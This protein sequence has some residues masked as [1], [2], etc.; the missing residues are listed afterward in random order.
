M[1]KK[2]YRIY[3]IYEKSTKSID[4]DTVVKIYRF[5]NCVAY[6]YTHFL[7]S[8][9]QAKKIGVFGCKMVPY[10]HILDFFGVKMLPYIHILDNVFVS[11][12]YHMYTFWGVFGVKNAAIY[13][14]FWNLIFSEKKKKEKKQYSRGVVFSQN[15]HHRFPP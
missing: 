10:I 9:P 1:Y 8:P 2:F 12:C 13:T 7:H 14:H 11:K 3:K 4:F 6:I 15:L 5:S